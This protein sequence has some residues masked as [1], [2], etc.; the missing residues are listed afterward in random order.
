MQWSHQNTR[1]WEVGEP[2]QQFSRPKSYTH[3]SVCSCEKGEWKC[4][5]IGYH[6]VPNHEYSTGPTACQVI[7]GI[8]SSVCLS[9]WMHSWEPDGA[10]WHP[11]RDATSLIMTSTSKPTWVLSLPGH[12]GSQ[13]HWLLGL[14]R[15][16]QS[17][18]GDMNFEKQP[19]AGKYPITGESG[20]SITLHDTKTAQESFKIWWKG[21][22]IF[23]KKILY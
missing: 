3:T 21:N 19:F 11:E 2:E 5:R 17:L 1:R 12:S 15:N 9:A 10:L 14:G 23:K 4:K 22:F 6:H 20:S 7:G 13:N 18:P 8:Q 16:S